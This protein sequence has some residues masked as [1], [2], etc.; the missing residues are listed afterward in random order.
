M[1]LFLIFCI[2]LLAVL[3]LLLFLNTRTQEAIFEFDHEYEHGQL[4]TKTTGKIET[5]QSMYIYAGTE[6]QNNAYAIYD[7]VVDEFGNV[8]VAGICKSPVYDFNGQ[9]TNPAINEELCFISKI[10]NNGQQAWWKWSS[11]QSI[12]GFGTDFPQLALANNKLFI[13]F[14]VATITDTTIIDFANNTIPAADYNIAI[15]RLDVINGEQHWFKLMKSAGHSDSTLSIVA[16]NT[17][18]FVTGDINL[19][20]GPVSDFNGSSLTTGTYYNWFVASINANNGNQTWIDIAT[21]NAPALSIPY[22]KGDI[23]IDDDQGFVYVAANMAA[24]ATMT[25]F[26]GAP[27]TGS[28]GELDIVIAKINASNGVQA[29]VKLCGGQNMD[30]SPILALG[31]DNVYISAN[32]DTTSAVTDFAGNSVTG[33]GQVDVCFA[34]LSKTNGVQEFF[35]LSGS[36]TQDSSTRKIIIDTNG[37]ILLLGIFGNGTYDFADVLVNYDGALF[38]MITKFNKT[39]SQLWKNIAGTPNGSGNINI[40]QL[41][42]QLIGDNDIVI[43]EWLQA[44]NEF[45]D[46]NGNHEDTTPDLQYIT[47]LSGIDGD[48][49]WVKYCNPNTITSGMNMGINIDV[50]EATQ[51]IIVSSRIFKN[52]APLLPTDFE[53]ITPGLLKDGD[54][55]YI[56]KFSPESFVSV[57]GLSLGNNKYLP[58]YHQIDGRE[59]GMSPNTTYFWNGHKLTTI[60]TNIYVGFTNNETMFMFAPKVS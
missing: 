44:Y 45:V 27:L 58:P 38:T 39:G 46:F 53:G 60:P 21:S 47:R 30:T 29:W 50:H 59:F 11:G 18:V 57:I 8:Y 49:Q 15:S 51:D 54:N 24:N 23:A 10:D 56:A 5:Y 41:S 19:S 7:Q 55:P 14:K 1:P 37:D 42:M 22:F 4:I 36:A 9:I 6:D 52:N 13:T 3:L 12:N 28:I 33:H 40:N 20:T 32:I 35:K 26:S 17:S 16:T 31:V 25:S 34:A 48:Q 43:V 2:V